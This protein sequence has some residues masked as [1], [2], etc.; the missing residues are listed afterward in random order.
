MSKQFYVYEWYNIETKEIF[1]VGKG[2]RNRIN[3]KKRRNKLFKEY[4]K[5]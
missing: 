1:Y 4:I 3:H 2:T 5:K